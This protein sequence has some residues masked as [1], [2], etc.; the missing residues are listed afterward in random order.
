MEKKG[1]HGGV[2]KGAGR[3]SKVDEDKSRYLI[4]EAL[5]RIYKKDED[6]ENTILFLHDFAQTPK[7]QQFVA[8]HLLGKPKEKV[9]STVNIQSIAPI[10]WTE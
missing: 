2:R 4:K 3:P 9:E 8:E 7:G 10:E 1:K 5:R 6:D